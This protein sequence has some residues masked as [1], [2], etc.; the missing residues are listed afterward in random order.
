MG[1]YRKFSVLSLPGRDSSARARRPLQAGLAVAVL[2]VLAA[3]GRGTDDPERASPDEAPDVTAGSRVAL[4]EYGVLDDGSKVTRATLS[5]ANGVEVDV[6]SYGGIITRLLVPDAEGKLGDIV[7]GLDN[8]EEYV[9]SSPYFGAIIGRYGNRIADGRF[10]LDGT[11]H[12]LVVNDG[13]NHLHGGAEGFD[14]R[15]WAMKPFETDDGVGLTLTLT[16]PDGDQGYPGELHA[17]VVY[18]LSD[19]NELALK[20]S[21]TTDK[22]TIVNLTHHSYFNLAG[23]GTILDHRLLIP[24]ER[25]T[26]VRAGLIPTGELR[27][28]AG[29]PFDFRE[30][31]PIGRDIAA[32]NEQLDLGLGYDH[33]WVLKQS[34][35]DQ[36]VLAARLTDPVSGRILEVLSSEPGIQ[37]YSGNFLDGSLQGKGVVHG[38][39]TGLCLEPQHFPDSPNQ[40]DFPE[41][42]LRPGETYRTQIVY[43]FLT[44]EE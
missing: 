38:H 42:T 11:E 41:T 39:R 37:F 2:A 28:V 3:C 1:E 22:A 36:L 13:D 23:Q 32:D 43:R 31:K 29:T 18:E 20:F 21:A 12:Q 16:S 35:G 40:P 24:A 34:A 5:N 33:N 15:N 27:E 19:K 9:T 6:I 26:P 10:E 30:P 8:L 7:L 14:K 4:A 44:A 17:E 25:F